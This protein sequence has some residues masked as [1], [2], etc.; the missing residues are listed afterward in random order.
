MALTNTSLAP[1]EAVRVLR[2]WGIQVG[3]EA[4]APGSGTAN[5]SAIVDAPRGP[6]LLRRRNPRYAREQWVRHDHALFRHLRD[7][8]LPA[9]EGVLGDLG[10]SWLADA[11][12]IYELFA[13]VEAEAHEEGDERELLSAGRTL[14]GI[15]RAA[16]SFEPP[17]PKP[18]P[19]FHDPRDA[20]EGLT[21]LL[22][23]GRER[24]EAARRLSVLARALELAE[25][26][27][28]RL[29]D[30]RYLS[31]PQ[32]V[33]H[34]DYHPGN[35]KFREHR[36]AGVFD[37]D[38]CSRQPRMVDLADGLLFFCGVRTEP[39]VPGDIWSL[40]AA[41]TIDSARVER[42]L[43]G[44]RA[45]VEPTERELSALPD[46]MRCRWLYC[47]VDAAQRKVQPARRAEF[48]V[49]DLEVPLREID[50]LAAELGC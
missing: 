34:G 49:R 28:D 27:V 47:R 9:P 37:W 25:A 26:L 46:L 41:M 31:L 2:H 50:A 45:G 12:E 19:R 23:L 18:W 43:E 8:G 36:V 38:W 35:L 11:G 5:A 13:Y 40:T 10:R 22:A 14:A 44:Y 24:G 48:V 20:Q 32:T 17:A 29:P 39:L 15:H 30:E 7:H 1:G 3:P 6:V 4:I 42:F 21:E 33:V 16:E